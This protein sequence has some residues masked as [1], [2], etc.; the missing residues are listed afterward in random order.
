MN[1]FVARVDNYS[2][3]HIAVP[4]V[5]DCS[6]LVVLCFIFIFCVHRFF[7]VPGLIFAKLCHTTRYV[8][9]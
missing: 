1:W 9:K 7:N 3:P 5:E 6:I 8:L 2:R 4:I